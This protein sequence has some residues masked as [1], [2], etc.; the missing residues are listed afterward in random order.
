M[1][2]HFL[3]TSKARSLSLIKIAQLSDD[4]TLSM[5][6]QLRWG[7]DNEQVCPKCGVK[8]QAY[9]ISTRKQWQCK[10]CNILSALH[11]ARFLP[12]I[13]YPFKPTYSLLRYL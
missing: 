3:L 5:L 1:A 6:C 9:F 4:E 11:Q 10:H 2:Q 8:H 12:I 7:S 13:S